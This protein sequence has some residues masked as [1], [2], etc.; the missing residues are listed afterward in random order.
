MKIEKLLGGKE[1][2]SKNSYKNDVA[3]G[4]KQKRKK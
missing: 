2:I 4:S 1:E 3:F